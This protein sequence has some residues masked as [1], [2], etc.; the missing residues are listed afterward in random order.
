MKLHDLYLESREE[1]IN[2]GILDTA[3]QAVLDIIGFV[4]G[5]GEPA[6]LINAIISAIKKDWLGVAA[7]LIS[8]SPEPASDALAKS[9]IWLNKAAAVSGQRDKI[10]AIIDKVGGASG[11][12]SMWEST[13][14]V[15]QKVKEKLDKAGDG[16][17]ANYARDGIDM[18]L[19]NW[20]K[21][22]EE[23]MRSLGK[24]SDANVEAEAQQV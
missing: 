21:I 10:N 12:E 8:M 7:R 24:I 3:V 9:I 22:N 16:R 6:D 4:P 23:L 20:D 19:D 2:E 11:I 18:I 14:G 1:S 5:I 13:Y 17:I 15:I